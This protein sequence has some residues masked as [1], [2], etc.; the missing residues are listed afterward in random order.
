MVD[1]EKST[2]DE[3]VWKKYAGEAI[4]LDGLKKKKKEIKKYSHT[5]SINS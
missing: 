4:D 5:Q 1:G 3:E 2:K